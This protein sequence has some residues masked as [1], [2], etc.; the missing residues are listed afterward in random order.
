MDVATDSEKLRAWQPSVRESVHW[1]DLEGDAVVVKDDDERHRTAEPS[2]SHTRDTQPDPPL[3]FGL[4]G[5]PNVGKSSLLNALLGA[6]RVSAGR[7]P[8][9][10]KHW[11]TLLWGPRRE[12]RIV[13]CPGLVCPSLVPMEMQAMSGSE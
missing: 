7:T 12:V 10:T 3:T 5:Q 11:Q 6:T 4:I 9:K 13:D 8:G 1:T 2:V